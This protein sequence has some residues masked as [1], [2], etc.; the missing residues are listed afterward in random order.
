MKILLLITMMLMS[1]SA[2]SG[3]EAGNGGVGVLSDDK[4]KVYL[5]DFAENGIEES[6]YIQNPDSYDQDILN[7]VEEKLDKDIFPT[8]LV[9]SKLTELKEVSPYN[10]YLLTQI[11]RI[12][13][14]RIVNFKVLDTNDEKSKIDISN[15]RV[16]LASRVRRTVRINRRYIAK[17]D[18][19]NLTGLII[20]EAR[21]AAELFQ[22]SPAEA[23]EEIKAACANNYG[24]LRHRFLECLENS[25]SQVRVQSVQRTKDYVANLFIQDFRDV[26]DTEIN[27][28][29][30]M[31]RVSKF[32]LVDLLYYNLDFSNVI[33]NLARRYI[34]VKK[35]SYFYDLKKNVFA[36][37][38]DQKRSE[39]IDPEVEFSEY[40]KEITSKEDL[41]ISFYEVKM[42]ILATQIDEQFRYFIEHSKNRYSRGIATES[43]SC[44]GDIK[45]ILKSTE[46]LWTL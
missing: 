9:A 23:S 28:N 36:K 34:I 1:C 17:L 8:K 20:H 26:L 40:C 7:V 43:K 24:L 46:R 11:I 5:L 42:H 22:F 30:E 3:Q 4:T 37:H 31:V 38:I 32:S 44:I 6:A 25:V 39:E 27:F 21:Y 35:K 13:N 41:E 33:E 10:S 45:R 15:R 29:R 14:W 16:Q 2:F 18:P 19:V 12:L